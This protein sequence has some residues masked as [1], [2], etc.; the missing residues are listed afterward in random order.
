MCETCK[1]LAA[2]NEELEARVAMLESH[3]FNHAW[4]SPRELHLTPAEEAMIR[5]MIRWGDRWASRDTLYE[6]TRFGQYSR[7]NTADIKVVDVLMSKLRNKLRPFNIEI[8][9][10]WGRGYSLAPEGRR[11]LLNWN[12]KAAA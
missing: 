4:Q 10:T 3:V 6:A 12:E 1:I 9:T 5:V 2:R 7:R 11:R 8:L